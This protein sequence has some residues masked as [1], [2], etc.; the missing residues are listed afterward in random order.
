[1]AQ[2]KIKPD[3]ELG[4]TRPVPEREPSSMSSRPSAGVQAGREYYVTMCPLRLIPRLFVFDEEEL[5]PELRAQRSLNKARVPEMARYIGGQP[6][7]LCVLGTDGV[8]R[9]GACSSSPSTLKAVR[10][11]GSAH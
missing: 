8:D 3:P 9:C 2:T 1:M 7:E 10:R 11:S 4:S 6:A 5:P